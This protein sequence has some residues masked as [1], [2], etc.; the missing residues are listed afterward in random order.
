MTWD[1]KVGD[2]VVC[3]DDADQ[4]AF[5][6]D[7]PNAVVKDQIYTVRWVGVDRCGLCIRVFGPR[8]RGAADSVPFKASRFRPIQSKAIETFRKIAQGVSDGKPIV[9][10]TEYRQP[11]PE[12]VKA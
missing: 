4:F 10:D 9:E 6:Y 8:E 1:F 5:F 11:T 2:K 7:A 3:V 12:K